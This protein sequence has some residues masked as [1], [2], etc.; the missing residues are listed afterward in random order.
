VT[1]LRRFPLAR[2]LPSPSRPRRRCGKARQA[3][4]LLSR[5]PGRRRGHGRGRRAFAPRLADGTGWRLTLPGGKGAPDPTRIRFYSFQLPRRPHMC[6]NSNFGAESLGEKDTVCSRPHSQGPAPSAP[7]KL[8]LCLPLPLPSAVPFLQLLLLCQ[9]ELAA[10]FDCISRSTGCQLR[11]PCRTIR[12]RLAPGLQARGTADAHVR[13]EWGQPYGGDGK[14]Y[15]PSDSFFLRVCE[16][17]NA[18][19]VPWS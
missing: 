14:S 11:T 18:K 16:L 13:S 12:T 6:C 4:P 15:R 1:R 3:P 9:L 10:Q 2:R 5:S 8:P 19:R 7:L 17:A